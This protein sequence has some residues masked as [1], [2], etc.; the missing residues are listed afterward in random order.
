MAE[1]LAAEATELTELDRTQLRDSLVEIA[2]DTPATQL[3]AARIKRILLK[4][5]PS[6]RAAIYQ[7]AVDVSSEIGKKLLTGE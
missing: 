4:L 5:A 6:L 3:A 7:F 2:T 1:A